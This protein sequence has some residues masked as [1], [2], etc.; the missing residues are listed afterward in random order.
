METVGNS[1]APGEIGAFLHR[2]GIHIGAKADATAIIL[3]ALHHAD[4]AGPANSAV[5]LDAPSFQLL[6]YELGGAF[7]LEADFRMRMNIAPNGGQLVCEALDQVD[8]RHG[9]FPAQGA[10]RSEVGA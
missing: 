8:S 7:L 4:D 2:Q 10:S 1:R 3:S 9:G 5:H 6:R